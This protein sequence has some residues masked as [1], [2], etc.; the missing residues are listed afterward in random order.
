MASPPAGQLVW[1]RHAAGPAPS[2]HAVRATCMQLLPLVE[3]F[4]KWELQEDCS[5]LEAL[6][7]RFDSEAELESDDL[8]R[9]LLFMIRNDED[10][11]PAS[12]PDIQREAAPDLVAGPFEL[13]RG[14][15]APAGAAIQTLQPQVLAVIG[16]KIEFSF[17]KNLLCTVTCSSVPRHPCSSLVPAVCQFGCSYLIQNSL[18]C[19]LCRFT[20]TIPP[21]LGSFACLWLPWVFFELQPPLQSACRFLVLSPAPRF[22]ASGSGI[23]A[24]YTVA[25]SRRAFSLSVSH[26]MVVVVLFTLFMGSC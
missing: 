12:T 5:N 2:P 14:R 8:G 23:S 10:G 22:L 1:R 20:A 13:L 19:N 21:A 15:L 18:C 3:M 4:C 17:R 7:L 26:C 9:A 24:A 6:M 11:L 25:Q 16:Y